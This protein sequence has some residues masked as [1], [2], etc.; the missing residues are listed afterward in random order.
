MIIVSTL[1]SANLYRCVVSRIGRDAVASVDVKPV[2]DVLFTAS[3]FS[4]STLHPY[5]VIFT[6]NFISFPDFIYV[7]FQLF[8]LDFL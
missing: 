3:N 2:S 6:V 1:K 7:A 4:S 8:L 5:M